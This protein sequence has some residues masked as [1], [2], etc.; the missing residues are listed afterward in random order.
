MEW[1][2]TIALNEILKRG[3]DLDQTDDVPEDILDDV[4][5]ELSKAAPL[6]RFV[7]RFYAPM[8]VYIFN[9]IMAEVYDEAD[10]Q[11]VWL[12]I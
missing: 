12:G 3:E 10:A 4:R 2:Y 9:E 5:K 1:K 7:K 8:T 6:I 11:S